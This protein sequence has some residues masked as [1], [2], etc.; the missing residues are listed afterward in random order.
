MPEKNKITI[1]I[2]TAAILKVVGVFLVLW[3]IYIIRDILII[4]FVAILLS[5][6]LE[7]GVKFLQKKKIP[8]ILSIVLIYV[9]LFLV[10]SSALILLIPP[11]TEQIGQ[12]A[13]SFPFYWEKLSAGFYS[14]RE[15]SQEHGFLDNIQQ[16]LDS[17]QTSFSQ[18]AGNIF[19]L[20][21]TVFGNIISFILI[22]VLTFYFLVQE[23]A[24]K[25]SFRFVTPAKYQPYL[26]DLITRMQQRVGLW[27]RGELILGLIIGSLSFIGLWLLGIK[28]FLVLAIIAGIFEL[29]PY[30]G[31]VLGAIPAVFIAF[32]QSPWKALFVLIL[33]WLIQQVENHLIVPKVMQKAVGLN[34]IVVIIVILVGAKLAGFIG[35]L[36]AVPT[37]AALS[38]VVKDFFESSEPEKID[39]K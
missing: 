29:I 37:A 15:Y 12:L 3:F 30:I 16:A 7:P 21:G 14:I 1:D 36:L 35:V 19:S 18:A 6:A 26:S 32:A 5:S 17:L 9:C 31:P 8:R 24:I 38:V 34:P 13:Q 28:Y 10:V 25:K 2:S 4:I 39:P 20:I 27:L 11:L 22:L 33:Y 23:N